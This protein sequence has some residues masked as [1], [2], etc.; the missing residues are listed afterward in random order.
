MKRVT[1]P[2]G[3]TLIE[4]MMA[5]A[6]L[7]IIVSL[8]LPGYQASIR[9]SRRADGKSAITQAAQA[10]ERCYTQYGAYNDG[11][12]AAVFPWNSTD[13]H[14][15]VTVVRTPTTFTLTAAP[16]G[17]QAADTS[18]PSYTLNHRGDRGPSPDPNRCW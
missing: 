8:A 7:A 16:Q 12:C 14:Y 13:G 11:N 10:L 9:K 5:L 1:R 6:V 4:L 3:F 18:C 17:T 15:T 2:R